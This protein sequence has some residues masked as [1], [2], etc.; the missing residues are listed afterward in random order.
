MIIGSDVA[1]ELRDLGKDGTVE[2][3]GKNKRNRN[4]P[5]NQLYH[6]EHQLWLGLLNLL[7]FG[8]RRRLHTG[9]H[10]ESDMSDGPSSTEQ[11]WNEIAL[12]LL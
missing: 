5:E 6:C 11:S 1:V 9:L 3:S 12:V 8:I 4:C 2:R 7:S 10:A